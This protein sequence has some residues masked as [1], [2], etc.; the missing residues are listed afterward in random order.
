MVNVLNASIDGDILTMNTPHGLRRRVARIAI[1]LVYLIQGGFG[2]SACQ[3]IGVAHM[4][5]VTT[6]ALLPALLCYTLRL[7]VATLICCAFLAPSFV[8]AN[9]FDCGIRPYTGGGAAMAYVP[10][11]MLTVPGS[12]ILGLVLEALVRARQKK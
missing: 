6:L 1:G 11:F 4:W 10:V 7:Y 9:Y 8:W 12:L 2:V 3:G 5:E